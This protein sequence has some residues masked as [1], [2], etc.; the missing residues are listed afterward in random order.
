[1]IP[2]LYSLSDG[3]GRD[4]GVQIEVVSG[5]IIGGG[6]GRGHGRRQYRLDDIRHACRDV[7]LQLG[8]VFE[9]A[10]ARDA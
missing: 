6:R 7:V 3:S 10:D 5:E 9:G 2:L 8:G 4:E 1:M